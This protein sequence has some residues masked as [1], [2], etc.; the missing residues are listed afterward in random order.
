MELAAFCR[1]FDRRVM[2]VHHDVSLLSGSPAHDSPD[3]LSQYIQ[4]ATEDP[5]PLPLA[6]PRY[7]RTRVDAHT[8]PRSSD[9]LL[10]RLLTQPATPEDEVLVVAFHESGAHWWSSRKADGSGPGMREVGAERR[11]GVEG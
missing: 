5:L 4:Q 11:Y 3:T 10:Q 9:P 1:T 7:I 2:V 8:A 6:S